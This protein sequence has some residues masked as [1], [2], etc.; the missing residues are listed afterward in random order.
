LRAIGHALRGW[1]VPLGVAVNSAV[2]KFT[3]EGCSDENIGN[4]IEI[5]AGQVVQFA[6][7]MKPA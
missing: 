6:K 5:M 7:A 1:N 2:V 4:Q 3:A